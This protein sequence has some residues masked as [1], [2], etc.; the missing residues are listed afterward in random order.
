[1]VGELIAT[2][3]GDFNH[4]CRV[5]TLTKYTRH[6][7]NE[8]EL[9]NV[10]FR[11]FDLI[12]LNKKEGKL[13]DRLKKLEHFR[14][15]L[16]NQRKNDRIGLIQQK[17]VKRK[18]LKDYFKKKDDSFEIIYDKKS[19]WEGIVVRTD[20][21]GYKIKTIQSVDCVIIGYAIGREG[22]RIT[23]NQVS[24]LLVALR[25]PDKRFQVLAKVGVGLSDSQR[26]ELFQRLKETKVE[27]KGFAYSTSDGR[28]F[29]M[30]KPEIVIEVEY[31]DLI[32]EKTSGE[33][34]KQNVITYDKKEK[35]WN[36][37]NR[38]IFPKIISPKLPKDFIREDKDPN[39]FDKEDKQFK[40]IRIQQIT[41]LI[42]VIPKSKVKK[43]DL[44]KSK[45][46]YI[47]I[48]K[49]E[50]KGKIR[51]NI[52]FK[53][54]KEEFGFPPY[55]IYNLDFSEDYWK[56][57]TDL[58]IAFSEKDAIQH[59]KKYIEKSHK[60][61]W[62]IHYDRIRLPN[63]DF[64]ETINKVTTGVEIKK[65]KYRENKIENPKIVEAF[66]IQKEKEGFFQKEE[67]TIEKIQNY[68]LNYNNL[69][70]I[71]ERKRVYR[72]LKEE[73]F[74]NKKKDEVS[75]R[76]TRVFNEDRHISFLL[77][78]VLKQKFEDILVE[79]IDNGLRI[80]ILDRDW[81]EFPE[82]DK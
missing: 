63:E 12:D 70:R 26:T 50:E 22:S 61:Y 58:K 18:E 46:L 23:P 59:F 43:E 74:Y 76:I 65:E 17:L 6:P 28:G 53:T 68:M 20:N 80:K 47:F 2:K 14:D 27:R 34:I 10:G 57:D 44:P 21:Y 35:E 39:Y 77:L 29:Q 48:S 42:D 73:Y 49:K 41:D 45:L 15:F 4:R 9:N 31:L 11:V 25:Y 8:T 19:G 51:K 71:R 32:E 13:K 52:V 66:P 75:V 36:L 40:D 79:K 72:N 62:D 56:I 38:V 5:Y 69:F 55:V 30:V 24:S 3:D 81:I 67:P 60:S 64:I 82:E 33:K 1:L 54:E 78:S 37:I 16:I 7:D